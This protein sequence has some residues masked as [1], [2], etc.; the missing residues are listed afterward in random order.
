MRTRDYSMNLEVIECYV[1]ER[2][3]KNHTFKGSLHVYLIDIKADLRG[4]HVSK[5]KNKWFFAL[6]FQSSRDINATDRIR[7]P[8]FSFNDYKK[9]DLM[10]A[11]IKEKGKQYIETQV[12]NKKKV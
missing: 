1:I 3:D 6:P 9:T 10:K 11:V 7:F 2:D 12:L 4:I 5:N 8:V